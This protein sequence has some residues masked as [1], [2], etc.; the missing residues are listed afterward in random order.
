MTPEFEKDLAAL[1][2][3]HGIDTE[4]NMADD[5]IAGYVCRYLDAAM[6]GMAGPEDARRKLSSVTAEE[7]DRV[8]DSVPDLPTHRRET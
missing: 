6:K 7:R 5:E 1:L 3:S 8:A 4:L 2:N